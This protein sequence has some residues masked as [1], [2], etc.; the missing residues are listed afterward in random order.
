MQTFG[1]FTFDDI[2]HKLFEN[3]NNLTHGAR[4]NVRQKILQ[5]MKTT[6]FNINYKIASK[7]KSAIISSEEKPRNDSSWTHTMTP[8]DGNVKFEHVLRMRKA[9]KI[10]G[11]YFAIHNTCF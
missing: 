3:A 2:L 10:R 1:D 6:N 4:P 8:N 7:L 5:L 11:Q 9:R